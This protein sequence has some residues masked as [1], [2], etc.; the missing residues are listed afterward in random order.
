MRS[1]IKF[2]NGIAAL[3]LIATMLLF[4][5]AGAIGLVGTH[6]VGNG[7]TI[8]SGDG[9]LAINA[10][11]FLQNGSVFMVEDDIYL[12]DGNVL[13]LP[14]S[15]RKVDG[16]T[17]I[18]D[19][20]LPSLPVDPGY[21]FNRAVARDR[22]GNTYILSGV[23]APA[24]NANNKFYL[25][26]FDVLGNYSRTPI[27]GSYGSRTHSLTYSPSLAHNDL[28]YVTSIGTSSQIIRYEI[29]SGLTTLIYSDNIDDIQ[30][31]AFDNSG[32]LYF[33][34]V[35]RVTPSAQ[36]PSLRIYRLVNPYGFNAQAT[37]IA[38]GLLATYP[39]YQS[40][41]PYIDDGKPAVDSYLYPHSGHQRFVFD[42]FNNIYLF[43]YNNE[44]RRID[45]VSGNI[46]TYFNA[47]SSFDTWKCDP[48]PGGS[49]GESILAHGINSRNELI[50]SLGQGNDICNLSIPEDA[51]LP[52]VT[53]IGESEIFI[54]VAKDDI[55]TELG[56]TAYDDFSG[57][58]TH[59]INTSYFFNA[60]PYNVGLF[61]NSSN[62]ISNF[63]GD[64]GPFHY[65]AYYRVEDASGNVG[66]A[67]RNVHVIDTR[68]PVYTPA[69]ITLLGGD[70]L[71]VELNSDFMAIDPGAEASN[72]FD[73]NLT[74]NIIIDSNVDTSKLGTYTVTY[75]VRTLTSGI[76]SRV[77]RT[78]NVVPAS[79]TT[80]PDLTIVGDNPLRL[81]VDNTFVDPGATA[82]DD[83]DGAISG[84]I[85][86][87]GSV[88]MS[89]IGTYTLTYTVED[90]SGNS[91]SES[92]DVIVLMTLDNTA[93][94]LTLQGDN[95]LQLTLNE[96]F[97]DPGATA[98]DNIDGDITAQISVTG[99]VNSA[100]A[101]SYTITYTVTDSSGNEVI[102][103]RE[104]IVA[105]NTSTDNTNTSTTTGSSSSSTG[106][107]G[108][109]NLYFLLSAFG[110]I[111]L[112]RRRQ[113][114]GREC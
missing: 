63:I 69:T 42:K 91:I 22:V 44:L 86:V 75:E 56:A 9:G 6:I 89:K 5:N 36:L 31:I 49:R 71:D 25:D 92:R 84:Q 102:S 2:S 17:G 95:P 65:L 74:S 52:V 40:S 58:L 54:D 109:I 26:F 39:S 3:L 93:P 78:V 1:E 8:S 96:A 14:I 108:S 35:K 88:D 82:V 100:V 34:V 85:T 23:G 48:L 103:S 99:S 21:S 90:S 60:L 38:G 66:E 114:C 47:E 72:A 16:V 51:A 70:P 59:L 13:T 57:D 62:P 73:G 83:I 10:G 67:W 41:P 4:Q 79:N 64:S 28:Y 50:Y 46:M 43:S 32:S 53:L 37:H 27:L 80:P 111:L 11:I 24:P 7:T 105:S 94:T 106:G 113:R 68:D 33:S 45:A 97:I 81:L 107:G 77:T 101:A 104:V 12:V 55:Y 112:L 110:L 98:R 29:D 19:E 30:Y 20:I 15:L 61:D 18:I 87:S 76:P